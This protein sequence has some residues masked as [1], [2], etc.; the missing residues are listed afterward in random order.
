MIFV[1]EIQVLFKKKNSR[2]PKSE[3]KMFVSRVNTENLIYF[4]FL[5]TDTHTHIHGN[6]IICSEWRFRLN[7]GK[8]CYLHVRFSFRAMIRST[9][10]MYDGIFK[11]QIDDELYCVRKTIANGNSISWQFNR[12]ICVKN[13]PSLTFIVLFYF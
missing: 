7:T 4:V 3:L 6:I 11:F 12:A 5:H 8:Y 2:S 13:F 9:W 1:R 10:Y